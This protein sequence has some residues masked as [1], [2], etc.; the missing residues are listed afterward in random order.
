MPLHD[1]GL[2]TSPRVTENLG[3]GR[4]RLGGIR[5]HMPGVWQ[6]VITVSDGTVSDSVTLDFDV[7]P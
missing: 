1:H 6:F 7:A 5:F 4:Y 2:P 3:G